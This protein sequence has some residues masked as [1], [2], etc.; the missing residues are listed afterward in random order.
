MSELLIQRIVQREELFEHL[1]LY[2]IKENVIA[3]DD[4]QFLACMYDVSQYQNVS[5]NPFLLE[6]YF[7]ENQT[8]LNKIVGL[9]KKVRDA[10]I[11]GKKVVHKIFRSKIFLDHLNE[12]LSNK[13]NNELKTNCIWNVA[14]FFNQISQI[15]HRPAINKFFDDFNQDISQ[16]H[17][18]VDAYVSVHLKN[19]VVEFEKSFEIV[20]RFSQSDLSQLKRMNHA[21]SIGGR[22]DIYKP[23][24]DEL[25]EIKASSLE[26]CSQAWIIQILC[27]ALL[28]DVY[29]YRK[30]KRIFIVNVLQGEIYRF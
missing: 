21:M 20:A 19:Q 23:D 24:S 18:N 25:F 30:V 12:F 7:S 16:L 8:Y 27:Y 22:L 17:D 14:L 3:T 11:S 6:L 5:C 9:E 29:G 13:K 1:K 26:K 10:F 2:Q 15:V 28:L 4:E